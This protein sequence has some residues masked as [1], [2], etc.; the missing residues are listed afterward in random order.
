LLVTLNSTIIHPREIFAA[1]LR[2]TSNSLIVVHNHPSG[3]VTPSSEDIATTIR[4]KECGDILGISLLDHI[5][6]GN[7]KFTSLCDEGYIE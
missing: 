3:D 4:L 7:N 5:I 6:I 1:A 2:Y